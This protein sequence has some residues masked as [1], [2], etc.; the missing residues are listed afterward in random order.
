MKRT[1]VGALAG[2]LGLA[3]LGC[4]ASE[5][6][7]SAARSEAEDLQAEDLEPSGTEL[8]LAVQSRHEN[9]IFRDLPGVRTYGVTAGRRDPTRAAI[10]VGVEASS[11][12]DILPREL[13]GVEVVAE[14]VGSTRGLGPRAVGLG[15]GGDFSFYER[16]IPMGAAIS[17]ERLCNPLNGCALGTG[18]LLVRRW[19]ADFILTNYHVVHQGVGRVEDIVGQP[20]GW[21]PDHFIGRLF[22]WKDVSTTAPNT[23]DAALVVTNNADTSGEILDIGVPRGTTRARI[24]TRVVK[25]GIGTGLTVGKIIAVNAQARVLLDF[26]G[27]EVSTVFVDQIVVKGAGFCGPGDSGSAVLTRGTHQVVGLLFAG[28]TT[29][30]QINAIGHVL[31]ELDVSL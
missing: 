21:N 3:L 25:S 15:G 29:R 20:F 26:N 10:Y 12:L 28:S 9:A 30:C 13:D 4:G 24:G 5:G 2:L 18:G 6:G 7:E 31:D 14:V 8:A 17:N 11:D 27:R 1:L 16:P 19:Y 22:D 23:I